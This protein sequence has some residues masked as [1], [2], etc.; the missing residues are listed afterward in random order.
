MDFFIFLFKNLISP[1]ILAFSSGVMVHKLFRVKLLGTVGDRLM[2]H[3]Y[4]RFLMRLNIY[5]LMLSIG[6]QGGVKLNAAPFSMSILLIF[7][8]GAS[9]SFVLPYIYYQY[10]RRLSGISSN[11][12][13]LVGMYYGS[14]SIVTF[15]AGLNFLKMQNVPYEGHLV[16]VAALMEVPAIIMGFILL[17][18]TDVKSGSKFKWASLLRH[19]LLHPSVFLLFVGFL[20]T[21]FLNTGAEEWLYKWATVPFSGSVCLFLLDM[22]VKVAKDFP[23][24]H[25]L[26]KPLLFFSIGAPILSV[27]LG[28]ISGWILGLSYGGAALFSLLCASASYVA[29]PAVVK[30]IHPHMNQSIPL[31]LSLGV[32][33]PFNVVLC[34]PFALYLN[35]FLHNIL[36]VR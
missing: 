25:H 33:F 26:P 7:L 18:R 27:I 14:I 10:L 32:T 29:V 34:V 17:Q 8:V 20:G 4:F 1:P 22:G 12:S 23:G 15:I 2:Y 31:G 24:F 21:I 9:F 16:G 36:M 28:T 13:V 11:L 30:A 5:F 6:V 3:P 19:V 35:L